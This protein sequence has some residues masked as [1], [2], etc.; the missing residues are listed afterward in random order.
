MWDFLLIHPWPK[1]MVSDSAHPP[2]LLPQLS[3]LAVQIHKIFVAIDLD[4]G[5]RS[6]TGTH[7][8]SYPHFMGPLS[9][10]Y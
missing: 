8:V 2:S 9:S 3:F 6:V 4:D 7:P 5:P 1:D 10:K